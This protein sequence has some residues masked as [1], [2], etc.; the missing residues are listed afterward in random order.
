MLLYQTSQLQWLLISHIALYQETPQNL[1]R[2]SQFMTH[3]MYLALI[4]K[5]LYRE[6]E[7]FME[8]KDAL[9]KKIFLWSLFKGVVLIK[10]I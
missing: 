3:S 5:M 2:K 8:I 9:K 7:G 4:K 1:H 6:E 10:I